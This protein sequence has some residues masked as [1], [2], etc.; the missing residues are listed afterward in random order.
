MMANRARISGDHEGSE[1]TTTAFRRGGDA[2]RAAL[3]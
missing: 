3:K 2:A 1:G